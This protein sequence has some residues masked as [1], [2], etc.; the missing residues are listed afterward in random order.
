MTPDEYRKKL[1]RRIAA[2][3]EER[4]GRKEKKRLKK[5]ATAERRR[6]VREYR[7]EKKRKQ[8][9]Q[10]EQQVEQKSDRVEHEDFGMK[11]PGSMFYRTYCDRCDEPMRVPISELHFATECEQCD[12]HPPDINQPASKDDDAGPWYDNALRALEDG[13]SD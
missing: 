2:N 13:R 5:L 6:K 12:P 1:E 3:R 8:Q 4:E 9:E 11:I 10:E 7:Q